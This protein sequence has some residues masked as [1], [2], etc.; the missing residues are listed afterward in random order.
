MDNEVAKQS[1]KLLAKQ[2][3]KFKLNTKVT[4]GEVTDASVNVS[5]E[6]A[7]GGKEETVSLTYPSTYSTKLTSCSSMRMSSSSPS[8]AVPT[9]PVLAS[10]TSASRSTT[11]AA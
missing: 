1:Q 9:L 3:L 7:K 11:G 5:V 4:A 8:V 6:A 10:T 2:G